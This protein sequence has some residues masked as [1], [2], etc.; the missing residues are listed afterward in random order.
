[1]KQ[2]SASKGRLVAWEAAS[3]LNESRLAPPSITG[4]MAP[5]SSSGPML[6]PLTASATTSS[7]GARLMCQRA[8]SNASCSG[9]TKRLKA[10]NVVPTATAWVVSAT[11]T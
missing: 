6:I 4:R 10:P 2:H 9:C 3:R 8:A 11:A 5:R 7:A 1:M